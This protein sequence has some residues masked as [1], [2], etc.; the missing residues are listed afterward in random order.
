MYKF[1]SEITQFSVTVTLLYFFKKHITYFT[2][3]KVEN[4]SN[5]A[6]W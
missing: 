2:E 1:F 3:I 6:S 5:I 4:S